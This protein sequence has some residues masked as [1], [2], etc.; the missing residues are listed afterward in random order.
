MKCPKCGHMSA[1]G[2]EVRGQFEGKAVWKCKECG[3]GLLVGPFLGS[4]GSP[5][6]VPEETWSRMEKMWKEGLG[7][8]SE[9]IN[10]PFTYEVTPTMNEEGS[11]NVGPPEKSNPVRVVL[12]IY[13]SLVLAAF[14]YVPWHLPSVEGK[15]RSRDQ[16]YAF[17]VSP[18]RE[19][20]RVNM[21]RMFVELGALTAA[22]AIGCL[23]CWKSED[24]NKGRG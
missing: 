1:S 21:R 13:A 7:G 2:F 12:I 11:E 18:P 15:A 23:I 19:S 14:L 5:K 9:P 24:S 3:T 20:A 10:E 22:A 16:G 4:W 17:L 6:I 8:S